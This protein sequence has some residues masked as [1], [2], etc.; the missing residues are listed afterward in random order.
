MVESRFNSGREGTQTVGLEG[1]P[2]CLGLTE[3]EQTEPP[4]QKL[5]WRPPSL[6]SLTTI[7]HWEE[8]S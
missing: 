4:C 6:G 1:V 3:K 5:T 2:P 8:W 7:L